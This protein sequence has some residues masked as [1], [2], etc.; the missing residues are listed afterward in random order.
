MDATIIPRVMVTCAFSNRSEFS[1]HTAAL[2]VFDEEPLPRGHAFY[3][4]ENVLLSPN[5][6]DH[7]ADWLDNA[8]RFFITQFERFRPGERL[9]NLVDKKLGY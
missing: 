7:T 8:M 2:D 9:A 1:V 3:Q 5:C 6:A 4:L